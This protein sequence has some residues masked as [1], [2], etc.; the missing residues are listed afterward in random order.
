[1]TV[2][3]PTVDSGHGPQL[4]TCCTHVMPQFTASSVRL[5][6]LLLLLPQFSAHSHTPFDTSAAFT[7]CKKALHHAHSQYSL[8]S[9]LRQLPLPSPTR[10]QFHAVH[11]PCSDQDRLQRMC[12]ALHSVEV[13]HKAFYSTTS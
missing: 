8:Y 3:V 13:L 10:A 9:I 11:S 4:W 2:L 5:P 12:G 1:M 7:L 6:F